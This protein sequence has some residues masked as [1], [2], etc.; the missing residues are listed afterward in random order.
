MLKK[1]S[2]MKTFKLVVLSL[3]L[4]GVVSLGWADL[5]IAGLW[6]CGERA[7]LEGGL[8]TMEVLIGAVL[9][10]PVGIGFFCAFACSPAPFEWPAKDRPARAPFSSSGGFPWQEVPKLQRAKRIRLPKHG[11]R[12]TV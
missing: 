3:L 10:V 2:I 1:E 8:W 5:V 12:K 9:A 11:T 7:N 4:M 6:L